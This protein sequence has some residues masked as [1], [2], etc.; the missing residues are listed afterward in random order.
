MKAAS[1]LTLVLAALI[2]VIVLGA[3]LAVG[4]LLALRDA[5]TVLVLGVATLA[6]VLAAGFTYLIVRAVDFEEAASAALEV[7]ASRD[8][9]DGIEATM[10]PAPGQG[11]ALQ[12]ATLPAPYLAA[13]M[14][15]LQANSRALS[16]GRPVAGKQAGC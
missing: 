13:V 3:A 15:G 5:G 9:Q 16:R 14:N 1:R 11:E 12:V 6:G 10:A 7:P 4:G 8:R 2:A